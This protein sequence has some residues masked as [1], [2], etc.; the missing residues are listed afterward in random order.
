MASEAPCLSLDQPWR[1]ALDTGG[2]FTDFVAL[3]P[4]ARSMRLKIPSDGSLSA[5]CE[6]QE[7]ARLGI[8][9]HYPIPL[10]DGFLDGA[11]IMAEGKCLGTIT[12]HQAN[13]LLL[14][15]VPN[16]PL[17]TPCALRI[18]W[19]SADALDAPALGLRIL[20]ST[21]RHAPLP[22]IELRLSTT[23]GTNA[24][25]EGR[26][27]KVGVL[28]S[29]GL[30]GI[31]AIGDQ[32]RD[33]LFACVPRPR[34]VLTSLVCAI[35]ERSVARTSA[36]LPFAP[37]ALR[38][39]RDRLRN[40]AQSLC[41]KGAQ[42]IVVS[43]A[44]ALEHERE[45]ALCQWLREDGFH[46]IAA[47]DLARH[48]R[49]LTRTETAV[50]HATIEGA[51]NDFVDRAADGVHRA[52]VHIF[53]SAGVL[54][55]ADSFYARDTLLSGPAGGAAAML[56]VAKRHALAHAL[57]F[58]MGGTST[59]VVRIEGD[60]ISRRE[61]C[62]VGRACVAAPSVAIDT[63]ASGGGSICS[64]V[65]GEHRVGPTSA[66]AMPGPA[67]M[68]RGGPL[69]L[70]DVN[71]LLGRLPHRVGSV[72]LQTT[73]SQ[74]ALERIVTANAST[75]QQ[76]RALCAFLDIA[77]ARMALAIERL[78]VRDA[79]DPSTHTLIA[80]GGAGGQHACAIADRLHIEQI[81][82][83]RDAG[84][85]CALGV[86]SSTSAQ[87]ATVPLLCELSEDNAPLLEA[88]VLRAGANA[89]AALTGHTTLT[90]PSITDRAI[91]FLRLRGQES[92][93]AVAHASTNEMRA[94]FLAA[95][96]R[97]YGYEAPHRPLEIESV[98]VRVALDDAWSHARPSDTVQTTATPTPTRCNTAGEW[99]DASI[100]R[101]DSLPLGCDLHGPMLIADHGDT[102]V[103][104]EGWAAKVHASGDLIA[105][106]KTPVAPRE[107][108]AEGELFAARLEAIALG[109]GELLERTALSPNIRDRLDFSCAVLDADGTLVQNAPH[110]PVH[111]G[112]LGVCVREVMRVLPLHE[113]DVAITNH[114]A[115]GG[116]HL[117]DLTAIAPVYL[118][119]ERIAFVAVRAHHAE[120]G[121]TRPGSFPPDATCLAEEGVV[122]EPIT[123]IDRGHF[124]E[125]ALRHR[126]TSAPFPS[127]A[128]DENLADLSAQFAALGHG[129]A[130]VAALARE[131]GR[132][133][134]TARTKR[135]LDA[136]EAR[137]RTVIQNSSLPT[138][139]S[140]RRVERHLDDGTPI[141]LAIAK[142]PDGRLH[143]DFTGS[144][145]VHP[146]NFNAPLCV[147]RAAVLYALRLFVREPVPMNEGLLRAVELCVPQGLLHPAFATDPTEC[148]P[149]VAG[150]VETS[151]HVVA[152]MVEALGLSADSQTTMNNVLFGSRDFSVYETLCGGAGAGFESDGADAVHVHMSNTR[153]TDIDVLERRAS[154]LI[155]RHALREGSGGDGLHRGGCGIVRSYEFLAPVE[156]SFFGSM[157]SQAPHGREGGSN[158][159]PGREHCI[160]PHGEERTLVGGTHALDLP[161]GSV[162][163]VESPGGGGY[164][165]REA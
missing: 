32:T 147:T 89:H 82:F 141:R 152:A 10:R 86:A 77:N 47:S 94:E 68:D 165:K 151:Q 112:A 163:T 75:A 98:S 11:Q 88:S 160:A 63:V 58:D 28:V 42:T 61:E 140:P 136:S 71:L 125:A 67:A 164:G 161:A 33:D 135:E 69:T 123:V 13:E 22:P 79:R 55:R 93:I 111:L 80:F 116:S 51:M 15:H 153:L 59:D 133:G 91:V 62:R 43:L 102:V 8:A 115:F 73:A 7:G 117:P 4:L 139:E 85:L 118:D 127:R 23:R 48:G 21:A 35:P 108:A 107:S 155:R 72:A 157:R 3:S 132:D 64:I 81:I 65:D 146:A 104:D 14:D 40:A 100:V 5:R 144:S 66:G 124:D 159:S 92:A 96:L 9:L 1:V 38:V 12:R 97:R 120:I 99:R 150:N 90:L 26:G 142:L 16:L 121:G 138:I 154:V 148:P 70:T 76:H 49:L 87:F 31:L 29:D 18:E 39:S 30:D 131:Q 145:G 60:R 56:E 143:I 36:R 162:F 122:L 2:S 113:G 83:P 46:A 45:Q 110:L 20:T 134:F 57:G 105:R 129:V 103:L 78:A 119:N 84:Y 101:R 95:F 54:Q 19:P 37:R 106:R 50:V 17:K 27:T 41:A 44:H 109:M 25:L 52:C 53:T 130:L 6:R 128:P 126:L 137:L 34:V 158:G 114:P 156:L 149:V 24:L 74:R